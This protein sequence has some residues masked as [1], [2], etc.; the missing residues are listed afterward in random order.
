[1]RSKTQSLLFLSL[2]ACNTST[3]VKIGTVNTPPSVTIL[4]PGA[5]DS[6]NEG[7]VVHFQA[8]IQDSYDTSPELEFT[9]ASDIEGELQGGT[10]A[11]INGNITYSTANLSPGIHVVSLS[12]LDS[13][14]AAASASVEVEII[15]LPDNPTITILHPVGDDYATEE[16]PFELMVSVWDATDPLNALIVEMRSDIAGLLC[17]VNPS[18]EGLASCEHSFDSGTHFLEFTVTNSNEFEAAASTYLS[19]QSLLS[20]DND[21]DGFSENQGD[22]DD[23]D[24]TVSPTQ[25]EVQNGFDDDC[26]TLIDE[27]TIA[28]DD[29]GD[30]FCETAPCTGSTN[31]S[32]TNLQGDDCNDGND[33]IA[34]DVTEICG[35]GLDNNCNQSQNEQNAINCV[36]FYRDYDNDG[37]GDATL[38]ECWCSAGG[39]SGEFDATNGN[40]CYDGNSQANPQQTGWFDTHRGD[41]SFDYNCDL[42][43]TRLYTTQ[44]SCDSWYEP[45]YG[46]CT[47]DTAGWDG[48]VPACGA[49]GYYIQ[50]ND[51]CSACGL[52]CEPA[53]ST[54][55]SRTQECR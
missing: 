2:L 26:D 40:D 55:N 41:G 34:P 47:I 14:A 7:E 21:G 19:V 37:Y 39:S 50:D 5:E 35:D 38:T 17:T 28:F 32:C 29:D 53:G 20:I 13:D 42:N 46:D 9:W 52:C 49:S 25:P 15:D 3:D 54:Y 1:M 16:D 33:D 11:D 6:F 51:S 24:P 12:V 48:P 44:G 8:K 10:P 45:P 23:I 18:I 31:P 30:C 43:E 4:S 27:G 22:C 36:T